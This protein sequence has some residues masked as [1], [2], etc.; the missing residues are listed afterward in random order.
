MFG[1]LT[2]KRAKQSRFRQLFTDTQAIAKLAPLQLGYVPWT[3]FALKP[4][5]M[6]QV[7]NDVVINDRRSIVEFGAGISTIHL[8]KVAQQRIAGRRIFIT[9]IEDDPDWAEIVR[10]MLREQKLEEH[11]RLVIAPLKPCS[12]SVDGLEWYD[13]KL[14][15]EAMGRQSVDLVMVDGPKAYEKGHELAR[16]PAFRAV[17]SA[18]APRCAIFLDDIQRRGEQRVLELWRREPGFDFSVA[19][20]GLCAVCHRGAY[21]NAG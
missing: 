2:R 6:L 15:A 14:V 19:K 18:L 5:V 13:E 3:A 12:L 10:G 20:S 4:T 7:I 21:F 16:F 1:I 9:S 17:A 8:A 11:V